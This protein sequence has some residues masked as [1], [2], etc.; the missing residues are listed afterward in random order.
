MFRSAE[1]VDDAV[2]RAVSVASLTVDAG[3]DWIKFGRKG[4][5]R[6]RLQHR[7]GVHAFGNARHAAVTHFQQ[8]GGA[9][10]PLC[11]IHGKPPSWHLAGCFAH[12]VCGRLHAWTVFPC[13]S[14]NGF[15]V[16][17]EGAPLSHPESAMT[18]EA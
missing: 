12:Y 17:H 1:D 15:A 14:H 5:G 13:K 18:N 4:G 2:A 10:R 6:Y 16:Y 3:A 7:A 8:Q 11:P 9:V